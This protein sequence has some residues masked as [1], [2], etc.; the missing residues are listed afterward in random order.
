MS[1]T[2]SEQKFS[3]KKRGK[4]M[5]PVELQQVLSTF[6]T[7]YFPVQNYELTMNTNAF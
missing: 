2:G 4:K 1:K 3:A 7:P 6:S 5:H